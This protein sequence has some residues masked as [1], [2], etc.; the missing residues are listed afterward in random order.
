MED[1]DKASANMGS[2]FAFEMD[3]GF[4]RIMVLF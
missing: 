1:S 4:Q 2:H 3:M